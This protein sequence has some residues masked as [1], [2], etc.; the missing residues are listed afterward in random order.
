MLQYR[1]VTLQFSP[2][3]T[4]RIGRHHARDPHGGKPQG[5]GQRRDGR[6]V[7]PDRA[8]PGATGSAA[9][10]VI[11]WFEFR[12]QKPIRLAQTARDGVRHAALGPANDTGRHHYGYV[13]GMPDT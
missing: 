6:A 3:G 11:G 2:D 13:T 9:N 4:K 8:R 12:V 7:S 5:P 1:A 10:V